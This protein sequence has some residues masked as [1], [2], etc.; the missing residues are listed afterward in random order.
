MEEQ[1]Q[2]I[3]MTEERIKELLKANGL[4]SEEKKEE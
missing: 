4:S 1:I 2:G 3:T